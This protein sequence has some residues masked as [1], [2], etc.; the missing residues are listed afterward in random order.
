[1]TPIRNYLHHGILPKH[2]KER[3]TPTHQSAHYLL[4]DEVLYRRGFSVP[5]LRCVARGNALQVL[6]SVH[7]GECGDHIGGQ[8]LAKK[9]LRRDYYWPTLDQDAT[10]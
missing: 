6:S 8:T 10:D 9:I 3:G 7:E 2:Y 5:F 1:M 4:M